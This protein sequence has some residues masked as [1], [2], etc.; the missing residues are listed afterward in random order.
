M[1]EPGR[2]TPD[3]MAEDIREDARAMAKLLSECAEALLSAGNRLHDGTIQG[4]FN[5]IA[6]VR[7]VQRALDSNLEDRIRQNSLRWNEVHEMRKATRS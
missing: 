5:A 6:Q 1:T 3:R 2:N 7:S 4:H